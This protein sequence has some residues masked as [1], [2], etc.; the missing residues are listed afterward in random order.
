MRKK[1]G[2]LLA[3]S[4]G[5]IIGLSAFGVRAFILKKRKEYNDYYSDFHRHFDKSSLKEND[6][7]VEFLSMQ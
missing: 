1:T 6:D 2:I 7:S 3:G 5:L 4:L